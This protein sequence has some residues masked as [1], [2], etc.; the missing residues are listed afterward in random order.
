MI[1]DGAGNVAIAELGVDGAVVVI[2]GDAAQL[3]DTQ[4]PAPTAPDSAVFSKGSILVAAT[5][6]STGPNLFVVPGATSCTLQKGTTALAIAAIAADSANL[7]VW[8]RTG[9]LVKTPITS[10]AIACNNATITVAAQLFTTSTAPAANGAQIDLIGD[11]AKFAVLTG[12][13]SNLTMDMQGQVTV[14]DLST[15]T[16]V[17]TAVPAKG[18]R[19]A[20]LGTVGSPPQ[21]IF[22]LGYPGRTV[23][24]T[25]NAGAV[26]I[27]AV[28]TSTGALDGD[29]L[30]TLSIPQADDNLLYGRGLAFTTFNSQSILIVSADNVVYAY[31]EINSLYGNTRQ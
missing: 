29:A 20:A 21:T 30:T 1:G 24:E 6:T 17:G 16:Q 2:H 10:L 3:T 27:H 18:A 31:Y 11:P 4:I 28:D 15:F 26:E 7:F 14:V 8:T 5:P 23:G 22:A 13:D 19:T 9:D 12:F 25:A